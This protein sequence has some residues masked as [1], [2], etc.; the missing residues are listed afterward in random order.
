M[1]GIVGLIT[2]FG[3]RDAY[4]GAMKAVMLGINPRLKVVDISHGVRSGNIR[5]ASYILM[6][7]YRFFPKGTV[8]T[9]VVDPGVGSRRKILCVKT[10]DYFFIAPDNGILTPVLGL[11]KNWMI[12]EVTNGKYFRREVSTTFHGR[13]KFAPDHPL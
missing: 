1:K 8:F 6:S 2:D 7:S 5:E 11:E 3:A 4:V 12:R 10:S 13:D 9:T